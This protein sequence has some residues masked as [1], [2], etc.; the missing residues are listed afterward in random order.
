MREPSI[1]ITEKNLA[2]VLAHLGSQQNISKLSSKELAKLI[3]K[4]AKNI[5][6]NNRMVI[7]S[8]QRLE[9]KTNKVLKASKQDADL[10]A[11]L[12]HKLRIKKKHRGVVK[13]NQDHRDWPKIKELVE[14]CIQFCNDFNLEK[15]DGFTKYLS[16]GLNKISSFRN[17]VH[18]L[19]SMGESI[20]NEYEAIEVIGNDDNPN[21]TKEI[22]DMYVSTISQNTG[23]VEE[24]VSKPLKYIHFI[25]VR[26]IT[27]ELNIPADIFLKAQFQSLAWAS[28]YP[29][30]HQLIGDKA[31]ERLNKYLFENKI[32]K[33]KSE[34]KSKEEVKKTFEKLKNMR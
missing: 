16:L 33:G 28:A 23:I 22:H 8:N 31:M 21:E 10:M 27:D 9:K 7:V 26:E 14:I 29:E 2:L 1:H 11:S 24:Y 18:K 13:M 34:R 19:V 15:K 30:P 6:C 12:I 32:R 4:K 25:R 17:H 20:A 5:S 3:L